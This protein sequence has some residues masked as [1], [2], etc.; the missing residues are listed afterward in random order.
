MDSSPP[1]LMYVDWEEIISQSLMLSCISI[2]SALFGSK[3]ARSRLREITYPKS[4]VLLLY[5]LSWA[6]TSIS[7]ILLTTND[8]NFIS[9]DI[10]ILTCDIFYAGSKI[11]IYLWLIE[12]VWIVKEVKTNRLD[13]FLYKFHLFLL[14]P[15]VGIFTLMVLYRIS[16]I[17]LDEECTIGVQLVA[18]I[19][20]LVYDIVFNSYITVLFLR[21]L[22]TVSRNVARQWSHTGL[23]S[24]AR[25]SLIAAIV[26]LVISNANALVVI[27]TRGHERGL[28]CLAFCTFDV[29][30]NVITVHWVT[31]V[32]ISPNV[33]RDKLSTVLGTDIVDSGEPDKP[34][35]SVSDDTSHN[36]SQHKMIQMVNTN[37]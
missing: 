4:L 14:T 28:I 20:L 2:M 35:I 29:T 26:C 5:F 24:L 33:S 3:I 1:Q 30:S 21:P 10:S 32:S 17:N 22:L 31:S 8:G 19:P 18:S 36:G 27:L 25:R 7:T 11:V 34:D 37:K 16:Y 9:C 15:Y 13:T 12:R 6:F 23:Y